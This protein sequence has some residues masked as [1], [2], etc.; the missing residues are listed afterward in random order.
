MA[1]DSKL[2]IPV[3]LQLKTLLLEEILDDRYGLD[4]RLPTDHELCARHRI[5]RRR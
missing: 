3:Y 5:S 2:P 4:G 1:I